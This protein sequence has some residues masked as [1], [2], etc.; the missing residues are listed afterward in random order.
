VNGAWA[1]TSFD[2]H[3]TTHR[4]PD[5][6]NTDG[7]AFYRQESIL[8]GDAVKKVINPKML[9]FG[10]PVVL[11]S[12]ENPDGSTN[13]A[14][15]SSAWW[16]GDTAMLGM[17]VNSQTVR[18]L[19]ERPAIVLNLVDGD[20]VAAVDRL[21]LLTGRR[22]VPDYK[23]A[24]GYRYEPDKFAAAG[25]TPAPFPDGGPFG[26]AECLIQLQGEVRNIVCIDAEDSGLRAMEVAITKVHVEEGLL[27]PDHPDYFDPLAWDPMIMKFTEY[28]AGATLVQESSLARGWEMPPLATVAR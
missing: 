3:R 6:T 7:R 4:R 10:T 14:P 13:I 15:M 28:F 23:A 24:R 1:E 11:I 27:L 18:N 22:D 20:A 2:V 9:Y 8:Q 25:L 17:S 19:S 26:V 5:L 21:A 12:S 16:V